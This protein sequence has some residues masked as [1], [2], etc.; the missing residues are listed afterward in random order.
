MNPYPLAIALSLA[1]SLPE[2]AP[3]PAIAQ[4]S[5]SQLPA[6]QN[7]PDDPYWLGEGDSIRIDITNVNEYNGE[8]R[9]LAD[10][11]L[12]LPIVG[13]I[14]LKGLTPEQ[15]GAEITTR[16]A[17]YF[18]RPLATV[19]LTVPRQLRVAVVGEV[20]R[21]GTYILSPLRGNE[22]MPGFQLP[23]LTR[24]LQ[25]AGGITLSANLREVEVRRQQP[26][27]AQTIQLDL[28]ALLQ[29]GDIRQDIQL[30]DGDTIY[31]PTATHP[32]LA[33]AQLIPSASFYPTITPPVNVAVIGEV[34]RPGSYVLD[35][36]ASVRS[37]DRGMLPTLTRAIQAAGGITTLANI[38]Q[39]ELRR[40]TPTGEVQTLNVNLG[41]LLETGDTTQNIVLQPGD[42]I[43]IP[44]AQ[45]IAPAD[46]QQL[47]SASFARPTIRVSVVG[48]VARPGTLDLPANTTLNQAILATGGLV[49]NRANPNSVELVRINPNGTLDR[50]SLPVK[51]AQG[52]NETT[53][54]PLRD[55]DIIVVKRSGLAEFTD[56]FSILTRPASPVL[57]IFRALNEIL[58]FRRN[59]Q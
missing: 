39:I 34:V 36:Q 29:D 46:F 22:P 10:G 16:Y 57:D 25:S 4:T 7:L 35:A 55:Q 44:T 30:R 12:V 5:P 17:K 31:I 18:K 47:A 52:I 3:I 24:A 56:F 21:P 20:N 15:A 32:N 33:E 43:F 38:R 8:Y 54:P 14:P 2:L 6:L 9:I 51:V 59:L 1:L 50:R 41:L 42:S 27:G 28:W 53:N 26:S 19:I 13:K 37:E 23:N 40:R 48:E 58:Y 11:T 49:P 45:V